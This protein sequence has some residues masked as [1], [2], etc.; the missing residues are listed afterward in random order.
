MGQSLA[1]LYLHLTFSTKDRY[2][3]IETEWEEKLYAYIAGILK[4][5][6][7]PSLIVNGNKDHIHVLFVLSKNIALA[8]VVEIVK[9]ESSKWIKSE[10][11]SNKFSWQT[12]YAC[13]SVSSSKI[14][15]I[16]KYIQNQIEHH[17]KQSFQ[18]EIRVFLNEYEI[19]FDERYIWN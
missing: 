18:N 19:K 16:K 5:L 9:K 14:E 13:F 8:K 2:P 7:S 10:G 17:K 1:K 15:T 4:N 6:E 3:F 11:F 12:G